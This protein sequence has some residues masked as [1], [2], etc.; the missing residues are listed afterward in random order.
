MNKN[1]R[2]KALYNEIPSLTQ[3]H[4]R[5]FRYWDR[6]Y[7][8]L[9]VFSKRTL[10]NKI[11]KALFRHRAML[12][13]RI[14][15]SQIFFTWSNSPTWPIIVSLRPHRITSLGTAQSSPGGPAL[16]DWSMQPCRSQL[17]LPPPS[18]PWSSLSSPALWQL[19]SPHLY[20]PVGELLVCSSLK[21]GHMPL[22]KSCPHLVSKQCFG[23]SGSSIKASS[24]AE[25]LTKTWNISSIHL[26]VLQPFLSV[27]W[28]WKHI[29]NTFL[30]LY[31][32][33][34][35]LK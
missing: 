12:K 3:R 17:F 31:N 10:V 33:S 32:A 20:I 2:R 21:A 22:T 30:A 6:W 15:V 35:S 19:P 34:N 24:W 26:C 27:L 29:F 4:Y 8:I 13:L 23:Q 18:P 5:Q 28:G 1:N 9:V 14:T 7:T 25:C 16:K 11:E